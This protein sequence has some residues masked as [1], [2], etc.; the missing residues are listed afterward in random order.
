[1]AGSKM[2][3][4]GGWTVDGRY[5]ESIYILDVAIMQW[6]KAA[7]VS[8][9]NLTN[10]PALGTP[11]IFNLKTNQWT[12][13]FVSI[14]STLGITS[15][16]SVDPTP[17]IGTIAP[18]N[19]P[20]TIS[21]AAIGGIIG[22]SAFTVA[23]VFATVSFIFQRKIST[24]N[25]DSAVDT[26][27]DQ[28]SAGDQTA[29]EGRLVRNPSYLNP[30][31]SPALLERAPQVGSLNRTVTYYGNNPNNGVAQWGSQAAPRDP[32][33]FSQKDDLNIPGYTSGRSQRLPNN[34]HSIIPQ[35][36]EPNSPQRNPH[37]RA[38]MT[39]YSS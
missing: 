9:Q 18:T 32:Q 35:A 28:D 21:K 3:L 2:V 23:V 26:E 36:L 38:S 27:R 1:Q 16:V 14:N 33:D 39:D 7:D 30:S 8:D 19:A 25:R 17:S 12:S 13:K 10:I 4:F 11:I 24:R 22:G 15:T 20:N 31:R 5:M 34:P 37:A 6:T 29:T